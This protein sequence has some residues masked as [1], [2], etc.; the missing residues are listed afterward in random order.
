MGG[1]F[2]YD[3]Y[4]RSLNIRHRQRIIADGEFYIQPGEVHGVYARR[5]VLITRARI[6][7]E[8]AAQRRPLPIGHTRKKRRGNYHGDTGGAPAKPERASG[9]ASA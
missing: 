3:R 1:V 8:H 9:C 2:S 4:L 6:E 5:V 7:R